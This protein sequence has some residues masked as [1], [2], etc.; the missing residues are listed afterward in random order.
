MKVYFEKCAK[1]KTVAVCGGAG[2]EFVGEASLCAD[3][4]ISS[5][6]SHETFREARALGVA[7]FDAGHYFTENPAAKRLCEALQKR[8]ADI[9]FEFYDVGSPFFTV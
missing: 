6:F 2:K 7:I 8:F 9:E 3:A 1:I 4:Y 5:D